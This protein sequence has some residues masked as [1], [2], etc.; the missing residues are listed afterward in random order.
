MRAHR[1]SLRT[2]LVA[3]GVSALL[4]LPARYAEGI[5]VVPV[6]AAVA[7]ATAFLVFAVTYVVLRSLSMFR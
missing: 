4:L 3:L 7:G 1:F 6:L 5:W 2:M